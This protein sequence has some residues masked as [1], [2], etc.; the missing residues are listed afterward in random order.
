MLTRNDANVERAEKAGARAVLDA[1]A[2]NAN[3]AVAKVAREARAFM[4]NAA[5]TTGGYYH[6]RL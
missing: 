4:P 2:S 6:A 3:S 1:A 5:A